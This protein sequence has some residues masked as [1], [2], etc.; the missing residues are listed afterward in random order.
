MST[1]P[2]VLAALTAAL[3]AGTAATA[4]AADGK[5]K[6]KC[7][8]IAKAGQNDCADL[9]GLHGCAGAARFD[10][11]PEEWKYVPQGTCHAAGGKT[12][13]EARAAKAAKAPR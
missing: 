2:I 5:A 12:A 7:Y 13:E 4:H 6:E 10:H 8:G 9:S 3:S 1:R 11:D